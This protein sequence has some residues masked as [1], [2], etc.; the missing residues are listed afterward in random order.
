[1]QYNTVAKANQNTTTFE[2][3]K[4]NHN[5]KNLTPQGQFYMTKANP[6]KRL[7]KT[8]AKP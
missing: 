5:T 7:V 6:A 4:K 2:V 1:M 3:S 8:T